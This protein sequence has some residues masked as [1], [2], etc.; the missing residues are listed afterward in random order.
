MPFMLTVIMPL[1]S[2]AGTISILL[3]LS[4]FLHLTSSIFLDVTKIMNTQEKIVLQK[5]QVREHEKEVAANA[6]AR[7]ENSSVVDDHQSRQKM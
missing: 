3:S 2:I 6:C 1:L 5:G 4:L 7:D